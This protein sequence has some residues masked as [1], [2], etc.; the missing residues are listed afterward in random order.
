MFL[1]T[2]FNLLKIHSWRIKRFEFFSS[3]I[4]QLPVNFPRL[5]VQK[6]RQQLKGFRNFSPH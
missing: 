2:I 5:R 3:R 1:I 6:F 4:A